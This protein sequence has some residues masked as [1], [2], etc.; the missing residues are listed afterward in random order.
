MQFLARYRCTTDVER[1]SVRVRT[2]DADRWDKH[3]SIE[4]DTPV[5]AASS[6]SGLYCGGPRYSQIEGNGINPEYRAELEAEGKLE[7]FLADQ[8]ECDR[9]TVPEEIEPF[10]FAMA[11]AQ[12]E[13]RRD[14]KRLAD[15]PKEYKA[16]HGQYPTWDDIAT[17]FPLA[18]ALIREQVQGEERKA[19]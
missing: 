6:Y 19:A 11:S 18:G 13:Y 5:T 17:E 15:W 10:F 4:L 7:A 1:V 9:R 14:Y 16:K 2:P 8:I 3:F 12:D